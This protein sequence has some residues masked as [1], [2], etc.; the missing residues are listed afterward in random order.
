MKKVFGLICSVVLCATGVFGQFTY[1]NAVDNTWSSL[2]NWLQDGSPATVLPSNTSSSENDVKINGIYTVDLGGAQGNSRNFYLGSQ[3]Y[4]DVVIT[5]GSFLMHK[6][7]HFRLSDGSSSTTKVYL[8]DLAKAGSSRIIRISNGKNS[9]GLLKIT[10]SNDTAIKASNLEVAGG[11]DSRGELDAG[12]KD[13]LLDREVIV[14]KGN[15]SVGTVVFDDVQTGLDGGYSVSIA[16]AKSAQGSFTANSGSMTG[17]D[18]S[19]GTSSNS[20]GI[21]DVGTG[22]LAFTNLFKV[23]SGKNSSGDITAGSISVEN[24]TIGSGDFSI[25]TV[26]TT[27]GLTL[28]DGGSLNVGTGIDSLVTTTE[29]ITLAGTLGDFAVGPGASDTVANLINTVNSSGSISVKR[30]LTISGGTHVITNLTVNFGGNITIDSVNVPNLTIG[31]GLLST[32]T[33]TTI[34]GLTLAD[35]GNLTIGTGIDSLAITTEPI[36]LAGTLGDFAV[37][38]GASETVVNLINTTDSFGEIKANRNFHITNGTHEITAFVLNADII[39]GGSETIIVN[40]LGVD[41]SVA[42][43]DGVT[44]A[45][46]LADMGVSGT[47]TGGLVK[48]AIGENSVGSFVYT[49]GDYIKSSEDDIILGN[50]INSQGTMTIS[51]GDVNVGNLYMAHKQGAIG[52]LSAGDADLSLVENSAIADA[53]NSTGT[54]TA[55]SLTANKALNIGTGSNAVA[56][57]TVTDLNIL[58]KSNIANA[59]ENG[60]ATINVTGDFTVGANGVVNMNGGTLVASNSAVL[61]SI[62]LADGLLQI[63]GNLVVTDGI[64]AI[65][66]GVLKWDTSVA[67]LEALYAT[68]K[69]VAN[70]VD[71]GTSSALVSTNSFDDLGNGYRM[72]F[73]LDD[74]GYATTFVGLISAPQSDLTPIVASWNGADLTLSWPTDVGQTYGVYAKTNL[75]AGTWDSITNGIPG[76]GGTVGITTDTTASD[77]KFYKAYRE[78]SE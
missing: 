71:S 35:G 36:T 75:V 48:V 24:L 1:T 63:D 74:S 73:G 14:A 43:A 44:K 42:T 76:T 27:S 70:G 59:N 47:V 66:N 49:G 26:T 65:E 67:N 57:I 8:T 77:S 52:T 29:P 39:Q 5:N 18:F 54:V 41:V 6:T 25:G 51:S 23:A 53:D 22:T 15:R 7:G 68:G 38:S 10:D 28:A 37:G 56:T 50:G 69:I 60:V 21:L 19:L 61:G 34:G 40:S 4:S 55:R 16:G 33:V 17:S 46:N 72:Y 3:S 11:A 2:G 12:G 58:E 20:V 32:G 13:L 45:F 30:N 78:L 64:I 31:S 9:D 62:N